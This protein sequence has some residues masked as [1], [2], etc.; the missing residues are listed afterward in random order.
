MSFTNYELIYCYCLHNL[1][2][3]S[4]KTSATFHL[5]FPVGL[6]FPMELPMQWFKRSN[7]LGQW[8]LCSHSKKS[9]QFFLCNWKWIASPTKCAFQFLGMEIQLRGVKS[10]RLSHKHY[11]KLHLMPT[12][13]PITFQPNIVSMPGGKWAKMGVS[14]LS[15]TIHVTFAQRTPPFCDHEMFQWH[16]GLIADRRSACQPTSSAVRQFQVQVGVNDIVLLFCTTSRS[17]KLWVRWTMQLFI[18]E[19]FCCLTFPAKR[20]PCTFCLLS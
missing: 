1:I 13:D 5:P 18:E 11:P 10:S 20:F 15:F 19:L 2:N 12:F 8:Y 6:T 16:I 14:L 7:S 3:W 9:K 17:V 4:S